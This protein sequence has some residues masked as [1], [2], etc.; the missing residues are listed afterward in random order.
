MISII[1]TSC[2]LG[3][4]LGIMNNSSVKKYTYYV[5][6]LNIDTIL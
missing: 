1:E 3:L 5:W 2:E 4:H 6:R